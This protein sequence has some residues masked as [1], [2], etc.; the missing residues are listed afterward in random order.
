MRVVTYVLF[1]SL[2]I[3]QLVCVPAWRDTE[4]LYKVSR[5][6][7]PMGHKKSLQLAVHH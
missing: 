7:T 5:R 1:R 6:H 3:R 4:G 2:L